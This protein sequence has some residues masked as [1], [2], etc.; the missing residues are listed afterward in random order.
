[1]SLGDV[2]VTMQ[3]QEI[4][5]TVELQGLWGLIS[6]YKK[7]LGIQKYAYI[8]ITQPYLMIFRKKNNFP[9]D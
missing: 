3:F 1:M 7:L 2:A 8:Y 5:I 6:D 9:K 4:T